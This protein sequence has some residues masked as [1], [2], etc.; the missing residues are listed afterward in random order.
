MLIL[1]LLIAHNLEKLIYYL[2]R[3]WQLA[4]ICCRVAEVVRKFVI[5]SA[6]ILC[7]YATVAQGPWISLRLIKHICSLIGYV[8]YLSDQI[9]LY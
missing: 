1:L 3:M 9:I 2:A 8:I 5:S 7:L 4:V 6:E